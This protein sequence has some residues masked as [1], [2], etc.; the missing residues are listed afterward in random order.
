MNIFRVFTLAISIQ[1]GANLTNTYYDFLNGVDTNGNKGGDLTLVEKKVSVGGLFTFALICYLI[2]IATISS[3]FMESKNAN[4]LIIFVVGITLAFFYTANPIGLKY[5]ALGDLTI[6]ICFGPLLM[7][8]CS[9]ILTGSINSSLYL[10]AI[11]VG[12]L[13]ENILHANNIRDTKSDAKA[14]ILTLAILMGYTNSL[15]LYI[16]LFI[17]SYVAAAYIGFCYHWGCL[18]VMVTIPL[19]A[20]LCRLCAQKK[21]DGLVEKTAE[22]HMA[23]GLL[24]FLGIYFTPQGLI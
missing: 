11:P 20:N 23:F 24:F 3:I 15:V 18:F 7:Q 8:C 6:F 21:F 9:I 19:A 17:G 13:T 1:S 10:Y 22:I 2:G 16:T 5:K 12:F 4:L 14:G